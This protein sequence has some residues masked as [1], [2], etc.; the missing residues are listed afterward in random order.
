MNGVSHIQAKRFSDNSVGRPYID[1]FVGAMIRGGCKKGIF[2]TSS[3]FSG[4]ARKGANELRE[5]KLKLIDGVDLAKSV[6][7][8]HLTLPTNREV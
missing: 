7:Y 2:V 6:S 8:T 4:D 3:T 5:Q 1:A